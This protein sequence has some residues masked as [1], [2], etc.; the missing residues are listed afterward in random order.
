MIYVICIII[1]IGLM[2]VLYILGSD[3]S[4]DQTDSIKDDMKK[5]VKVNNIISRRSKIY[6]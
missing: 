1:I 4:K 6:Q 5:N 2:F 3:D